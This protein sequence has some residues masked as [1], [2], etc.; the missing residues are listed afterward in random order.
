MDQAIIDIT[1]IPKVNEG[2]IAIIIGKCGK[3]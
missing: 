1:D 2:D 3:E